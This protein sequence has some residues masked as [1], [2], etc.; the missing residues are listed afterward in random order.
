MPNKNPAKGIENK[1]LP[2]FT[3]LHIKSTLIKFI[4]GKVIRHSNVNHSVTNTIK[5]QGSANVGLNKP[6]QNL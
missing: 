2:N 4:S 5:L 3:L 6:T 1:R